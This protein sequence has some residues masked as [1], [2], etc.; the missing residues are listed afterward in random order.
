MFLDDG[1]RPLPAP[2]P[3]PEMKRADAPPH[4]L[5]DPAEAVVAWRAQR[6]RGAGLDGALADR[7]A[8]DCGY[9]LHALI[10]LVERGCPPPLAVRILAPLQAGGRPC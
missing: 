3:S 6:L 7:V 1:V 5:A 2:T 4:R 10:A 9:D 8:R